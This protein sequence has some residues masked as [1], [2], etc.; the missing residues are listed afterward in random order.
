MKITLTFHEYM[1]IVFILE[2]GIQHHI[3]YVHI[4]AV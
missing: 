2:G 4:I 3:T 1:G